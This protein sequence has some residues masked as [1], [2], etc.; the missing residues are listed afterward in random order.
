MTV[1]HYAEA[2]HPAEGRCF[3]FVSVAGTHG[4][5]AHCPA[6]PAWRACT[7]PVTGG[8]T[9]SRPAPAIVAPLPR[10]SGCRHRGHPQG[11]LVSQAPAEPRVLILRAIDAAAGDRHARLGHAGDWRVEGGCDCLAEVQPIVSTVGA[12]FVQ[13]YLRWLQAVHDNGEGPAG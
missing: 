13:E 11:Q 6:P 5:P 12:T 7:W 9:G 1:S 3:R 10:P 8:D 2:L 4:Q